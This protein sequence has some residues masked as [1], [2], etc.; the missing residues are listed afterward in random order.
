M[1]TE[2]V[3][4]ILAGAKTQDRRI[5]K[6]EEFGASSWDQLPTNF[7]E[8]W[9]KNARPRHPKLGEAGDRLWVKETWQAWHQ[10]SVE[11][12][13]WEPIT[14]KSRHGRPWAA[15]L[16]EKGTPDHLEYRASSESTGPW[17]SPLYMP[18]WASRLTL[19]IVRVRVQ[20]VQEISEEDARAEG[21][22]ADITALAS[23]S[24]LLGA[25]SC[26]AVPSRLMTARDT[27]RARWERQQH[28]IT[29]ASNPWIWALTFRK[30][31]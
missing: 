7:G 3:P 11:Y 5:A 25:P 8:A 13:E 1:P 20:R 30:A 27:Y 24:H 12:D 23:L 14:A 15:Y 22:L 28:G 18:R 31:S 16:H 4:A 29:W 19:E 26:A 9:R 21:C 2:A 6:P 10:C 17:T